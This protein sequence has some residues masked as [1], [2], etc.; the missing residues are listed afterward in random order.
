MM[1]DMEK[2]TNVILAVLEDFNR[3]QTNISSEAARLEIAKTIVIQL[4]D[5]RP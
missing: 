3:N 1:R 5:E 2:V 4:L